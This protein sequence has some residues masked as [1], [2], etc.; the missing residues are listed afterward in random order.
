MKT[1][2]EKIAEREAL[3]LE[4]IRSGY[5]AFKKDNEDEVNYVE[6]EN[7]IIEKDD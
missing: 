3:E 5:E 4:K 7:K 1:D 2:G 6:E